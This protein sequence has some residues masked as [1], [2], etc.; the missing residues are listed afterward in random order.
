MGKL[1]SRHRK[2][3]ARCKAFQAEMKEKIEEFNIFVKQCFPAG[4]LEEYKET[5]ISYTEDEYL[6]ESLIDKLQIYTMEIL[7]AGKDYINE[8]ISLRIINVIQN[9]PTSKKTRFIP[10]LLEEVRTAQKEALYYTEFLIYLEML[11]QWYNKN[12]KSLGFHV[13]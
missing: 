6:I 10:R 4:N 7:E 12:L 1:K 2:T 5:V 3:V 8:T 9:K 11:L 13:E